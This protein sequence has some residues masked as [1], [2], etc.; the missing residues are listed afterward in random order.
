MPMKRGIKSRFWDQTSLDSLMG[1]GLLPVSGTDCEE[2]P[3]FV[4]R[5]YHL[6]LDRGRISEV[7]W[8]K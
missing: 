3:D 5:K 4:A 1:A 8:D 6:V 2:D 7:Q